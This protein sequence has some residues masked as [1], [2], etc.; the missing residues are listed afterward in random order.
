MP[1]RGALHIPIA[2]DT[3]AAVQYFHNARDANIR[4]TREKPREIHLP[5]L[6][7]SI[8]SKTIVVSIVHPLKLIRDF[9]LSR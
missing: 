2:T 9:Q 5:Y 7:S 3:A 4:Q 1:Q 6:W 8:D